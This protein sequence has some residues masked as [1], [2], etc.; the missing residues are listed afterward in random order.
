MNNA[1]HRGMA[2]RFMHMLFLLAAVASPATQAATDSYQQRNLASDGFTPADNNDP[3][4]KNSW[5]IAFNPF[6]PAWVANA[7]SGVATTYD[8]AGK[9]QSP[10]VEIP[11][12][13][14]AGGHG[15]PT[16]VVFNSSSGFV[17]SN[18]N[19]S[20]PSRLIFATEEGVIA[21]WAS[22]VDATHAIRAIDNSASGA[23]YKGLALSA[24]G[25]GSLLY[26]ADF[27]NNRIE[28]FDSSFK[29]VTLPAGAFSDTSLPAGFAPFGLQAINGDIYV[30][31]AR[32][33]ADR[34]D[35]VAGPG[36]GY[37]NVFDPE[38]HLLRRVASQG[39]LNAPW[40]IALAPAGFGQFSGRLLVGNF[41]DGMINAFDLATGRFAG[42]LKRPDGTPLQIEGLWGIHFGNGFLNQ[43]VNS[44]FFAAGPGNEQHGLY[45]RIDV[46]PGGQ[47]DDAPLP[48]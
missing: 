3:N 23:V 33:D 45:G 6:G 38:G 32:Q 41:G 21:G 42:T 4:L 44:L 1:F 48:Y 27:H 29:A 11:P 46:V 18:G 36:L 15:S 31:Y 37:I 25:N 43:S 28:V 39:A 2:I 19:A 13:A 34:H 40:G 24:G 26:A 30:A 9:P 8:G 20:G 16:G 5:G 7:A 12:A 22:N 17:V 14:N 35:D 47:G 10:V